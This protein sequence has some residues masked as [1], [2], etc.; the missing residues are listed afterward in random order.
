MKKALGLMITVF[1]FLFTVGCSSNEEVAYSGESE[2]WEVELG[3]NEDSPSNY[4]ELVILY[5]GDLSDLKSLEKLE[6]SYKIGSSG[7]TITQSFDGTT[8]EKKRF[9]TTISNNDDEI[10]PVQDTIEVT[11][12]WLGNKE[13][14]QLK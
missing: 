13:S 3:I 5:K 12:Q 7:G 11:V 10:E 4:K 8:I 14:I 6:Y 9:S 1:M 2:H